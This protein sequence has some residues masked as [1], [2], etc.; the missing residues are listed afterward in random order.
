MHDDGLQQDFQ[1]NLD[2]LERAKNAISSRAPITCDEAADQIMRER[3]MFVNLLTNQA[4]F[5][6][7][8]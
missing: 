8:F 7:D 2:F 1:K 6:R 5:V 4:T 3:H